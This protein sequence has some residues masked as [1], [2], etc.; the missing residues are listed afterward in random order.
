MDPAAAEALKKMQSHQ[1]RQLQQWQQKQRQ[2]RLLEQ[3]R[4]LKQLRAAANGEAA[5]GSG[6]QN[7][8]ED[9]LDEVRPLIVLSQP[10]QVCPTVRLRSLPRIHIL[11]HLPYRIAGPRLS[12]SLQL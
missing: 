5:G 8:N 9:D 4:K 10:L 3:Q 7:T 1:A 11:A 12:P 6:Q 2:K